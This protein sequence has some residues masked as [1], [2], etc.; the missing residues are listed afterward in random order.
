MRVDRRDRV[1]SQESVLD[2]ARLDDHEPLVAALAAQRGDTGSSDVA[3]G[4]EDALLAVL[5]ANMVDL[6]APMSLRR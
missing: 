4:L 2:G 6:D 5:V 3:K 1:P